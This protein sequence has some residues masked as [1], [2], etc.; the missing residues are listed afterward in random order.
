MESRLKT[1]EG[2]FK[3]TPNCSPQLRVI[4]LDYLLLHESPTTLQTADRSACGGRGADDGQAL[5]GMER[6]GVWHE[7][8]V[9]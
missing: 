1:Q 5:R 8:E 9:L 4:T 7:C 3:T 2:I 6:R